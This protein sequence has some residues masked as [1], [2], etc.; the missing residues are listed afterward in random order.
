[1]SCT[2]RRLCTKHAHSQAA[3]ALW[4]GL[5]VHGLGVHALPAAWGFTPICLLGCFSPVCKRCSCIAR[6]QLLGLSRC[7][8]VQ[9]RQQV[10]CHGLPGKR[11]SVDQQ[12]CQQ[13][14]QITCDLYIGNPET[15]TSEGTS[16]TSS[17]DLNTPCR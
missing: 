16:N 1:M 7:C 5:F 15:T 10:I 8:R 2:W 13:G 14:I 9:A 4:R 3:P 6:N 12:A 11:Q 17:Y